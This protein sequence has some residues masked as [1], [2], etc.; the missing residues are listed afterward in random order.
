MLDP[1]TRETVVDL[2]EDEG[3]SF[4]AVFGSHARGAETSD[5]DLDVLVS[6]SE[7]KSLLDLS[8]IERE[9]SEATGLDVEIVT[10]NALN[11]H[12]REAV[13]QDMEVLVG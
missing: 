9:T 13:E 3:A 8:R 10:R 11:P 12:I 2:L 5:S 4:V 7:R 6:F 1:E